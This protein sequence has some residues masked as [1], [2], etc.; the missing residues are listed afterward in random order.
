MEAC[1]KKFSINDKDYNCHEKKKKAMKN[2]YCQGFKA[3][4]FFFILCNPVAQRNILEKPC[5]YDDVNSFDDVIG[6]HAV[7]WKSNLHQ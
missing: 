6:Y 4:L 7:D 1:F 2:V 5:N 3:Y